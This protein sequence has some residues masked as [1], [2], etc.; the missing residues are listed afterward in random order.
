MKLDIIIDALAVFRL[1]KMINQD[2]IFHEVREKI[3][4]HFPPKTSKIGYLF[5]C[6]WCMSIWCATFLLTIKQLRPEEYKVLANIL[7]TSGVTG[8][9]SEHL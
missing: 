6:D 7:A 3:L 4:E 5:T 8:L 1:T 9:L 2:Y